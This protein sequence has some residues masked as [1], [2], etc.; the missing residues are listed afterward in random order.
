MERITATLL[1]SIA[2]L[3]LTDPAEFKRLFGSANDRT[4]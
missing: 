1:A 4:H 2:A 3:R